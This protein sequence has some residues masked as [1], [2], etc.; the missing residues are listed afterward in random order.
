MVALSVQGNHFL[1]L[2][3]ILFSRKGMKKILSILL[4]SIQAILMISCRHAAH[5]GEMLIWSS[6]NSQEISYISGKVEQWNSANPDRLIRAQP[7]PE[8]QSS[9]EIILASVVGGTTPAIY[10]NMWQGNVEMYAQAGVLV[11]LD[12][13]PGFIETITERC[14]PEAIKE[15]TSADGHI[16]QVPWKV[17]PIMTLYNVKMFREAGLEKLPRT[18]QEYLE[19]ARLISTDIDDDGYIDR[20]IGYTSVL[21]IWYQRLFNFYPLYL[22]ASNGAP[23]IENN[24]AAFNNQYAVGVFAFLQ[25][26][27]NKNYFSRQQ[28]TASQDPFIMEKVATL[29][30]G[31]WQVPYLEKFKPPD[32]EYGFSPMMV[33][34]ETNTPVYT[35]GDPKNIVI[36]N[37]CPDPLNAWKFLKTLISVE[38]DFDLLRITGQFPRRKNISVNPVFKPYFKE[39]PKLMPFAVQADYLKGVDNNPN[40]VEVFDIISQEY[41]ACV[42]YGRKTPEESVKDAADAVNVLLNTIK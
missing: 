8:G 16:Y 33:P 38:G 18:Y 6:N 39:N 41:E 25:D 20:W 9:E 40:I 2:N 23:L 36:F 42:L 14:T 26:L 19:A 24:R 27:Y 32:M 13:M 15:I 37:T 11:R 5:T 29:L 21:P 31:P 30:T 1:L 7:I 10:A 12:T 34:E 35:Y 3:L 22:A 17:N 28:M 4:F